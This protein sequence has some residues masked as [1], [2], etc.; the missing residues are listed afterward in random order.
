[1]TEPLS[2]RNQSIDL[3]MKELKLLNIF[4]KNIILYIWWITK[5][6]SDWTTGQRAKQC[7][8]F[9]KNILETSVC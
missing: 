9:K 8:F 7:A 5:F 3:L 1:M 4:A 6:L 2:Y